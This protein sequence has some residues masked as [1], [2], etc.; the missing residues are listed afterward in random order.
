MDLEN[1]DSDLSLSLDVEQLAGSLRRGGTVPRPITS[2]PV[3]SKHVGI[4]TILLREILQAFSP[5]MILI[6]ELVAKENEVHFERVIAW[7]F[8]QIEL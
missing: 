7:Q 2:H 3:I 8:C 5:L 6:A 4:V 1:Q